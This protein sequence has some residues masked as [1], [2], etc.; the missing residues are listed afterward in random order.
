M[1][2]ALRRFRRA[3]EVILSTF[4]WQFALVCL[5]DIV[6]LS[7]SWDASINHMK[8]GLTLSRH[9]VVIIQ[10][11]KWEFFSRTMNYLGHT[12][13]HGQ[14]PVSQQPS[15]R[16]ATKSHQINIS[17]LLSL[18]G[19]CNLFRRF[20]R[21]IAPVAALQSRKLRKDQL[22]YLEISLKN[23]PRPTK[24]VTDADYP[25]NNVLSKINRNLHSGQRHLWW[26]S[27]LFSLRATARC[28]IQADCKSVEISQRRRM[29]LPLHAHEMPSSGLGRISNEA[30]SGRCPIKLR[31]QSRRTALDSEPYRFIRTPSTLIPA[32]I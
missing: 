11:K 27:W 9:A 15:T 2:N 17:D 24:I 8:L 1:E 5:E 13:H 16:F 21:I 12:N 3:M 6:I 10:I 22:T 31:N 20:V 14:M 25:S 30:T 4:Q 32:P 7:K 26:A 23:F 28:T 19:S 18:L 29:L